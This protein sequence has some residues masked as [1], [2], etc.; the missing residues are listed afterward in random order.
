MRDL[1][2]GRGSR[3]ES[4]TTAPPGKPKGRA[5]PQGEGKEIDSSK[6]GFL[7]GRI[8]IVGT[9]PPARQPRSG[10]GSRSTVPPKSNRPPLTWLDAKASEIT[11]KPGNDSDQVHGVFMRGQGG[12]KESQSRRE[13]DRP[14]RLRAKWAVGRGASEPPRAQRA[15]RR[16][17]VILER[18]SV[19]PALHRPPGPPKK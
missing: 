3:S 17:D 11:A 16:R 15:T 5:P 1:Q 2:E 18:R 9:A 19:P 8:G 14:L 10:R 12:R 6:S 13:A 7:K 4:E